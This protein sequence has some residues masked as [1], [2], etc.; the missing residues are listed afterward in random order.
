MVLLKYE[1]ILLISPGVKNMVVG[2]NLKN[3]KEIWYNKS[4]KRFSMDV[5][6]LENTKNSSV[7]FVIKQPPAQQNTVFS[8]YVSK[9][10]FINSELY[11]HF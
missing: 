11:S 3:Q 6:R 8:Q 2:L 7:S 10:Y 9:N 5:Q 4:Q 1:E